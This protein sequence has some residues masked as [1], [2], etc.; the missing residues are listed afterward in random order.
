MNIK[1]KQMA[2][3]GEFL[4]EEAV[5]DVLLAAR[6]KDE[7][8]GAAEIG[9]RTGVFRESGYAKK[10]GNDDLV[11]GILGKL[12]KHKRVQKCCQDPEKP[13]DTNGWELTDAEFQQRRDD[14]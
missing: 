14:G 13:D 1:P 12:A 2:R 3:F 4:L 10:S 7:C 6:H 8:I 9:K 11:W 5:L